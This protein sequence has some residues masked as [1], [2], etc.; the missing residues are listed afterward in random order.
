[1]S[2]FEKSVST[3]NKESVEKHLSHMKLSQNQLNHA[4]FLSIENFKIEEHT[5]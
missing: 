3:N 5:D 1:M 4:L 2:S